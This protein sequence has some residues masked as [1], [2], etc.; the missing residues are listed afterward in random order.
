MQFKGKVATDRGEIAAA[1]KNEKI[2]AAKSIVS[3][4]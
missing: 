1:W 2:E 3:F 4:I